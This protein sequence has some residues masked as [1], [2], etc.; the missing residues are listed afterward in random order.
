MTGAG[1]QLWKRCWRM[2][3]HPKPSHPF[4]AKAPVNTQLGLS[5]YADALSQVINN[6]FTFIDT[7]DQ[8]I[9]TFFIADEMNYWIQTLGIIFPMNSC[10]NLEFIFNVTVRRSDG[11][12]SHTFQPQCVT[13]CERFYSGQSESKP[14]ANGGKSKQILQ[15]NNN[16][17]IIMFLKL[18]NE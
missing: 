7:K 4:H 1:C 16:I 2:A 12:G 15:V 5:G 8:I 11:S 6:C 9:L 10:P 18:N 3:C 17:I 13:W 14:N